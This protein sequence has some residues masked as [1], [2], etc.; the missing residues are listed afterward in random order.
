MT[1]VDYTT[2]TIANHL[3]GGDGNDVLIATVEPPL[4]SPSI[5]AEFVGG[6]LGSSFL[7]GGAGNDVL[8]VFG[9]S[10]N[11]LHGGE[12]KDTLIGGTGNDTMLGDAGADTFTFAALNGHDT[13]HFEQGQDKID[14]TALGIHGFSGLNVEVAGSNSIIHLD[15]S[16]DVT[17]TEVVSLTGHD[18]MFA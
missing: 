9:G 3:D 17:V 10:A 7:D 13:I 2:S 1:R 5:P 12:G 11:I 6:P 4:P 8:T 15:A 16:N 18:F 14:L